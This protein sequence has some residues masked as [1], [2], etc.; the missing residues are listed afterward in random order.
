MI[1]KRCG[2]IKINGVEWMWDYNKDMPIRVDEM[3]KRARVCC[4]VCRTAGEF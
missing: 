1:C 2:G 4:G 3:Q